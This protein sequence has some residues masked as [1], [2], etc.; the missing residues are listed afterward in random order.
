MTAMLIL[1]GAIHRDTNTLVKRPI[2]ARVRKNP[3][4]ANNAAKKACF[5]QTNP[6][7]DG[8]VR[9]VPDQFNT[10]RRRAFS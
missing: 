9:Q 3:A 10:R 7:F 4:V 8:A 1:L 5:M 6:T 2:R